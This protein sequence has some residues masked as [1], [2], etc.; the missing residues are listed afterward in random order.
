M[1]SRTLESLA[2]RAA[3]HLYNVTVTVKP[4]G[5]S[6]YEAPALFLRQYAESQEVGGYIPS[7][8]GE[9]I[10]LEINGCVDQSAE[11]WVDDTLY[12]VAN[13][14]PDGTGWVRWHL[15]KDSIL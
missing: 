12:R 11:V 5:L 8:E 2:N 10:Q 13:R 6:E 7:I 4:Y 15:E 3:R 14:E 9:E 1:P